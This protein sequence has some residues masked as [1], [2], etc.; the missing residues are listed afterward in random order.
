MMLAASRG[1]ANCVKENE[2]K[3]DYILPY[4]WDKRVHEEVAR[5]VKEEAIK[6]HVNKI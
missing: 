5:A 1:I 4:A 6:A 3:V 2:L